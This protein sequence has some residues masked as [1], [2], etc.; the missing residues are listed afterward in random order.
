MAWHKS[1]TTVATAVV[2]TLV[3]SGFAVIPVI[4]QAVDEP[5][6]QIIFPDALANT[7]GFSTTEPRL[8]SELSETTPEVTGF[9]TEILR[10]SI[11]AESG[12]LTISDAAQEAVSAIS[13][14]EKSGS[15]ELAFTGT[16]E[17]VNTALET[18]AWQ[19]DNLDKVKLTIEVSVGEG[20]SFASHY[21]EVKSGP[22]DCYYDEEIE[23][24]VCE[25]PI[26]WTDAYSAANSMTTPS[27]DG[28]CPGYLVTITSQEEQDFIASKMKSDT[29]IGASDDNA[30]YVAIGGTEPQGE[31]TWFWANGPEAGDIFMTEQTNPVDGFYNHFADGE[32]NDSGGNEDAAEMYISDAYWND[33]PSQES[34]LNSYIVEY[35]GP[36][37]TPSAVGAEKLEAETFVQAGSVPTA[38]DKPFDADDFIL[39]GNAANTGT[40][41]AL[42]PNLAGKNGSIWA[43]QRICLANNFS[44]E[45]QI[46]LGAAGG[47]G[48]GADG[49][50]FV[51]Q[52]LSV[53]AGGV[54]GG[55]GYA[56]ITPSF[57]V[58]FDTWKNGNDPTGAA[59]DPSGGHIALME[60]GVTSK[61][62]TWAAPYNWG[63]VDVGY[64]LFED[65]NF[66]KFKFNWTAESK[67]VDVFVD[68]DHNGT[69]EDAE[70]LFSQP[71][72][73]LE[74][75]FAAS[76]GCA[77][78]GFTAATGGSANLQQ[79]IIDK[80][81]ATGRRNLPPVA[82]IENVEVQIPAVDEIVD[83]TALLEDDSTTDTQWTLS[84]KVTDSAVASITDEEVADSTANLSVKGLSIG[85]TPLKFKAL[86]ADGLATATKTVFVTVGDPGPSQPGNVVATAGPGLVDLTWDAPTE[87]AE[88][89][90]DDYEITYSSDDGATWQTYS[91]T[92]S[93]STSARITG[94]VAGTEYVFRV[95]AKYTEDSVLK[96][97]PA[98]LSNAV[99]PL[100]SVEI[101][102]L[103][104][105]AGKKKV[106]LTWTAPTTDLTITDY[107]VEY[108]IPGTSTWTTFV[109]AASTSTTLDVT[110]LTSGVSYEFRVTPVAGEITCTPSS[111]SGPYV[112]TGSSSTG[113]GSSDSSGTGDNSGSTDNSGGGS[114]GNGGSSNSDGSSDSGNSGNQA[115]QDET[116]APAGDF[117]VRLVPELEAT[118]GVIYSDQNPMPQVL[119]DLLSGPIAYELDSLSGLAKLP[120]NE[121]KVL[122]AFEN[123][124]VVNATLIKNAA[125][126]GFII[127][128]D[129]WEL[130]IKA[131]DSTGSDLKLDANG[132]I[133]L[134]SD[135]TI[136]FRGEGFAPGSYVQPWLFSSPIQLD[137]VL[138]AADGTFTGK[139]FVPEGIEAGHHTIQVNGVSRDG[140]IRS[141]AIGI[142][143]KPVAFAGG[144]AEFNWIAFNGFAIALLMLVAIFWLIIARRRREKEEVI[145]D[146]VQLA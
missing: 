129:G 63:G 116:S 30:I 9:T 23:A 128:A 55:L 43:K 98:T 32:P 90:F 86:D 11:A 3:A 107:V 66:R 7:E 127:K 29:W 17:D 115:G 4:S 44:A 139:G 79:V 130:E 24:D 18:L 131:Q 64:S 106:T 110:G 123:G 52:P 61:H 101:S 38:T 83:I 47:L 119:E 112:P 31:G 35:G 53:A 1:K 26:D 25:T 140:L 144:S 46:Y 88:T 33:L 132:D 12:E 82:T 92:A 50:A 96:T 141:A 84:A 16:Q 142:T 89:V 40:Q 69:Y 124:K 78:W 6:K 145:S 10:I 20:L 68:I 36:D 67:T 117:T 73:D 103:T 125:K 42:T 118:P 49:I 34:F 21:Y 13:G 91:H 95:K 62:D 81:T 136:V 45:S 27:A 143:V 80:Y 60:N 138:V 121:P 94:L 105:V 22:E 76:E 71:D 85:T 37:C 72:I 41:I 99:T 70:H 102:G 126:T 108:R 75:K 114:D 48:T 137:K 135:R 113:G 51:I 39:N 56:G 28:V 15:S 74:T 65:G 111:A 59:G 19:A 5:I 133:V 134:N 146:N 97:S 109:H 8:I 2:G 104:G 122:I 100:D 14:Y 57:A 77:Y 58:E 93:S 54:G 87:P 120:E